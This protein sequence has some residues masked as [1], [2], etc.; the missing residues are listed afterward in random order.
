MKK[1]IE[2]I[3]A[4]LADLKAIKE[5]NSHDRDAITRCTTLLRSLNQSIAAGKATDAT[6]EDANQQI[7]AA[8]PKKPAAKPQTPYA[9]P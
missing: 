9:K 4:L 7:A 3:E 5:P 1:H 6:A 8:F 2:N